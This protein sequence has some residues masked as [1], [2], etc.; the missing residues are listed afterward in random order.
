MTVIFSEILIPSSNKLN[1]E[2][3]HRKT[4][5]RKL[6]FFCIDVKLASGFNITYARLISKI[7]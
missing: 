6:I 1:S 4:S 2:D 3:H 5:S 7:I